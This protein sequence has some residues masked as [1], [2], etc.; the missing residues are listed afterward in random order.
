MLFTR[1]STARVLPTVKKEAYQGKRKLSE[2][3]IFL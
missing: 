2:N 1:G 3:I